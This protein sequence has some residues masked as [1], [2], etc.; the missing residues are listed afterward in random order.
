MRRA[1]TDSIQPIDELSC[2]LRYADGASEEI[3]N[4]GDVTVEPAGEDPMG[5]GESGACAWEGLSDGE[6]F[7]SLSM[8]DFAQTNELIGSM[9]EDR[10]PAKSPC[11]AADTDLSESMASLSSEEREKLRCLASKIR[12]R[13]E[14]MSVSERRAMRRDLADLARRSR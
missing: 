11:T 9:A 13:I 4:M 7:P 5:D 6:R 8:D 12:K 2:I 1:I 3:R 14:S 10:R